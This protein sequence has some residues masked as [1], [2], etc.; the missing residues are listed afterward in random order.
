MFIAAVGLLLRALIDLADMVVDYYSEDIP[1]RIN[2]DWANNY[3]YDITIIVIYAGIAGA[4][5]IGS[6]FNQM[7]K[8]DPGLELAPFASPHVYE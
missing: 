5:V 8:S 3:I 2:L 7:P 1:N 4:A 6:G